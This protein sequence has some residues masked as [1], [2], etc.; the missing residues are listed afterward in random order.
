MKSTTN[1]WYISPRTTNLPHWTNSFIPGLGGAST[2]LALALP[3]LVVV[4]E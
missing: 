1:Y 3:P 4:A 2:A